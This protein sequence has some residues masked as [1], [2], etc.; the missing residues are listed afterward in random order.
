MPSVEQCK[1][2]A[3]IRAACWNGWWPVSI[4]LTNTHAGMRKVPPHIRAA[5]AA[6]GTDEAAFD[7]GQPDVIAEIERRK[8]RRH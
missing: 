8:R 4:A 5:L 1:A 6:H 7:T 3:A 2:Y